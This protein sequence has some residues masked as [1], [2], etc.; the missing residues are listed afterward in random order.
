MEAGEVPRREAGRVNPMRNGEV[1]EVWRLRHGADMPPG[2]DYAETT[3]PT[4]HDQFSR[5]I[6]R[7]IMTTTEALVAERGTTHGDWLENA[8]VIQGLKRYMQTRPGW[9]SL[10]PHEREALEMVCVKAGRILAGNPHFA[11]HWDD[12]AGYAKLAADRNRQP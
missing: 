4:M 12:I 11:D 2:W 9:G 5:S 10:Y 6:E 8:E 3:G 1:R 7:E